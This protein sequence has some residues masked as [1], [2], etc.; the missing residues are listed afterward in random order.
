MKLCEL[1]SCSFQNWYPKFRDC[2]IFSV[3]EPIPDNVLEYLKSD[4]VTVPLEATSDHKKDLYD[5]E[6]RDN[7]VNWDSGDEDQI[8]VTP[9]SFPEFSEKIKEHL[10]SLGGN[11]FIKLNWSS[12]SDA[13]W[14]A[15]NNSL[16]CTNLQD[17][18]LLL[19][20]SDKIAK[21]LSCDYRH[22]G[23]KYYLVMKKW[24][25]IHPNSEFRCFVSDN[26]LIGLSQRSKMDYHEYIS[27]SK[28]NIVNDIKNFFLSKIKSKFSLSTY[29]MDVVRT[30]SGCVK[31]IDFQLLTPSADTCL[32]T[33]EE[34]SSMEYVEGV[35]PEFRF[36]AESTGIQPNMEYHF[37]MPHD[38]I[39]LPDE[40]RNNIIRLLQDHI[41]LQEN[42]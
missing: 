31:V 38:L 24:K 16:K 42:Q 12:P 1:S 14:V 22:S 37:G 2:S 9:P 25:N 33:F 29:I 13:S 27:V 11:V 30:A 10:K 35:S 39:N 21:D 26:Q 5:C 41:N 15:T 6:Y 8:E 32:F 36:I 34:L 17:L 28:V 23:P 20:S 7:S 18:Y 4:G 40:S 19:K 3:F